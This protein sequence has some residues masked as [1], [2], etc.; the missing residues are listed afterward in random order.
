MPLDYDMGAIII[1]ALLIA[2]WCEA[3]RAASSGARGARAGAARRHAG[4]PRRRRGPERAERLVAVEEVRRGD[5]FRVRPGDR[6]PVDGIVIAGAS[7]V[8][9]SMLTGESLPVEKG[10]RRAA[11][12][13]D[14]ERR[15]GAAGARDRGR[16]R[17]RA[18]AAGGAR[19]AR[20]GLQAEDPAARRRDRAL[21]RA[22]RARARRAHGARV[23][24]H[25]PG[26][27]RACSPRCTS[28]AAW[29]RRSRC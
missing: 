21:L 18:L 13:R 19:R 3:R 28:S 23:G 29:T 15:R 8:D 1:A 12:R 14:G 17:H 10:A 24:A 20:A 5:V 25:R 22:H 11:D 6:V 27:C 2:R 9:E 16:R 7:A 4:A 26:P